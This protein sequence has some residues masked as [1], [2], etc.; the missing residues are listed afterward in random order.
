LV[1]D[2]LRRG[3]GEIRYAEVR[4]SLENR[5]PPGNLSACKGARIKQA[6]CS[7]PLSPSLLSARL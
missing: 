7:Q 3:M 1:R 6:A 4:D 2:S 5:Q